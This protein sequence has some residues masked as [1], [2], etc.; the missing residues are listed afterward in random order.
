MSLAA[1]VT[2]PPA[3]LTRRIVTSVV[4]AGLGLLMV[5]VFGLGRA[6]G[7]D[8]HFGLSLAA[9][10][11]Q[12][13]RTRGA[14]PG[15][16]RRARRGLPADRGRP[17]KRQARPSRLRLGDR[18]RAH[19]L[20]LLV[21]HLGRGRSVDEP[22]RPVRQLGAAGHPARARRAGR[23]AVRTV[24]C[25]QHRDRRAVPRRRVRRRGRRQREREPVARRDL[26]RSGRW[27]DRPG[28]GG[29]RDPLLR[30]PGHPR[31]RPQRLRAGSHRIS[32][33][34]A[35]DPE[36]EHAQLARTRSPW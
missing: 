17:G 29:V 27:P 2:R 34:P 12:G 22:G 13:A 7:V 11:R 9:C 10:V 21:P 20:R 31:C 35:A 4:F 8:A 6:P 5:T 28:S 26:G 36:P 15:D 16:V 3:A 30:Q 25:H 18:H 19:A 1:T 33:R 14:V 24:G 32:L 23:G